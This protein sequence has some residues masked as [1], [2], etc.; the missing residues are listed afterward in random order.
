[1]PYFAVMGETS[2]RHPPYSFHKSLVWTRIIEQRCP[3]LLEEVADEIAGS[4]GATQKFVKFL[5][6]FL[7]DEPAGRPTAGF[8]VRWSKT[9]LRSVLVKIYDYRSKALHAGVPFPAPMCVAPRLMMPDWGGPEERPSGLASST[10]GGV[11]V[12]EDLP[13]H[14]HVFEHICSGRSSSLV[15]ESYAQHLA[16][17]RRP[18]R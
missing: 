8:Q 16:P 14:F 12:A 18:R 6:H 10:L 1:M 9:N 15:A 7:P 5:L 3:D 13:L 17:E 11:W 2:S 4:L